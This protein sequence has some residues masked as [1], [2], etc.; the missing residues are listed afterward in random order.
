[1]EQ[2]Y[3][4]EKIE[5]L[6]EHIGSIALSVEE[7]NIVSQEISNKI[8]QENTPKV[9]NMISKIVSE[10]VFIYLNVLQENTTILE[11]QL[12]DMKELVVEVDDTLAKEIKEASDE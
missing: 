12:L 6:K 8:D 7:L 11:N 3:D 10:G 2:R 1:M 9:V 5:R 4:I